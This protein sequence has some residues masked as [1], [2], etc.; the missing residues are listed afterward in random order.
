MFALRI[1]RGKQ[2]QDGPL[3]NSDLKYFNCW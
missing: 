3:R 1:A 2:L